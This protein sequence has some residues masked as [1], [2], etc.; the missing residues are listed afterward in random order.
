MG[1]QEALIGLG[2][3]V[4]LGA[5]AFEESRPSRHRGRDRPAANAATRRNFNSEDRGPTG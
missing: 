4:L 3:I 1:V 5:L 2:I